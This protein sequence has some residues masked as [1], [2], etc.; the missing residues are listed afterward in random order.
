[1][2]SNRS[3]L[4]DAGACRR[5][6]AGR[7]TAVLGL[8]ALLCALPLLPAAAAPVDDAVAE[9]Q[10][11]WEVIRYQTP[12]DGRERRMQALAARAHQISESFPGRSEAL[13]CEG[14]VLSSW[15]GAK[16]RVRCWS[17]RAASSARA[18]AVVRAKCRSERSAFIRK[19]MRMQSWSPYSCRRG[20]LG[21]GRSR[22]LIVPF[23]GTGCVVLFEIVGDKVIVGAVRHHREQDYRR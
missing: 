16:R 4:A 21:S 9:V 7:H 8:G 2:F 19:G 5:P 14:I 15:A 10:R 13:V 6:K 1:M 20:E 17:G 23:G 12:A 22:E 3:C 11:D 18:A